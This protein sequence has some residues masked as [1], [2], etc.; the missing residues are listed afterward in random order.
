M[1]SNCLG[2]PKGST[3]DKEAEQGRPKPVEAAPLSPEEEEKID[4]AVAAD[5]GRNRVKKKKAAIGVN[6]G[7]VQVREAASAVVS[8]KEKSMLDKELILHSL[9]SQFI[10]S[11]WTEEQRSYVVNAMKFYALRANEVIFEQG[12][13]AMNFF[14]IADGEV[15]V[16]SNGV[17]R[18]VLRK[19]AGFG[20]SALVHNVARTATIRTLTNTTLWGL[21][22]DTFKHFIEGVNVQNYE[23]N[24]QFINSIQIFQTLT[25]QQ[26]EDLLQALQSIQYPAGTRVVTQGD[27]GEVLYIIREG[28][29]VC[30]KDGKEIRRMGKGEFFGEQALLYGGIRT[31]TIT[32]VDSVKLV[33][34][35]RSDLQ[36]ALGSQLLQVIYRNSL[37]IALDRSETLRRLNSD[38]SDRLIAAV[39]V[40]TYTVG[41]VVIPSGTVVGSSLYVVLKGSLRKV[42][43]P[44][45]VG[46]TFACLGD[47]EL[48]RKVES[49]YD[50]DIVVASESAD[51]AVLTRQEFEQCI[52]GS[53]DAATQNNEVLKVLKRVQLLRSLPNEK[54]LE[55]TQALRLREFTDKEVIVKQNNPGDSFF[56]IESGRVDVYRD[57]VNLRTI[58]KH[59]YF[60]ER[61]VLFG[62]ARTATIIAKGPV[63]CWILEKSEFYRVIDEQVRNQ[64]MKR[65]AL[66]DDTITLPDLVV[67]KALGKG[68][69][70]NVYLTTQPK[71]R[72]L[73]ALKAVSRGKIERYNIKDNILLERKVLL[74]LDHSMILKLVKTYKDTTHLYFLTEFVRG[75]DFFDVLRKMEGLVNSRDARFYT[76]C[77]MLIL[78]HL[79]ERDIIYRDLKP[80][81]IMIDEEGYMKLIDFGTAKIVQGRTYTIVGTPHYMAPEVIVGKGYG[82]SADYWSMGAILFECMCGRVP[83]GEEEEDP[84]QIYEK[85]LQHNVTYPPWVKADVINQVKGVLDVLLSK[86]PAM[87][88][89]GSI[90]TLRSNPWFK[91][92]NWDRLAIRQIKAPFVPKIAGLDDDITKA[93]KKNQSVAKVIAVTLTLERSQ[94]GGRTTQPQTTKSSGHD[95]G[96]GVLM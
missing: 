76:G 67:V 26:K 80:E 1:G 30:T 47:T 21:D 93:L 22:R 12:Q 64:L 96:S 85:I 48:T 89:S 54:L 42:N 10:Y 44:D 8:E 41:Q 39:H 32:A 81:N 13:P 51:I 78:E 45:V 86:N 55:L 65:I 71:S 46:D 74:Q 43:G 50:V 61:S 72:T 4:Q 15:E 28:T 62:D 25:P 57:G 33:S 63:A 23:E 3:E 69:F 37:R 79:H 59:D 82:M 53:L 16:L 7:A 31:A 29:V 49:Q 56:I 24:K 35:G 14:V 87:R 5:Q 90:A 75:L 91:G 20:E 52:G 40:A 94:G 68:M 88:T 34:I 77:M 58:T 6:P 9:Q 73:Y 11:T 2:C 84:Y 27:Q 83:F 38:Q 92:F 18:N 70:G 36:N 17:R 60:G 95:L 66:Q 19:G